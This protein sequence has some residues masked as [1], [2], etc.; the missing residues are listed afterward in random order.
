MHG[1]CL[2]GAL[3]CNDFL[4]L[5]RKTGFTDPRLDE[6]HR[7]TLGNPNMEAL[8][9][10]VAFSSSTYRLWK[11]RGLESDCEDYGQAVVYRGTVPTARCVFRLDSHHTIEA[12]RVFAV[13]GNTYSML[14]DTRLA[15]HFKFLEPESKVHLGLFAACDKQEGTDNGTASGGSCCSG[16]GCC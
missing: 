6:T 1:A 4:R 9:G 11:L 16:G 14:H 7:L 12:G 10:H 8:V 3:Y 13:C 15:Q 2:S 5:A